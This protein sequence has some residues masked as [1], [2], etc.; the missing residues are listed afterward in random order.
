[1]GSAHWFWQWRQAEQLGSRKQLFLAP[2]APMES[3]KSRSDTVEETINEIEIRE[4]EYKKLRHREQK[5][6]L[7]MKEY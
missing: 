5:G 4:D 2:Q 1:M 3:F 6:S 7:R